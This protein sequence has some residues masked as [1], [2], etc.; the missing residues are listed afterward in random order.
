MAPTD[1]WTGVREP[2]PRMPPHARLGALVVDADACWCRVPWR[3][4]RSRH[5]SILPGSGLRVASRKA[6]AAAENTEALNGALM[7]K[8]RV[9][10]SANATKSSPLP[11]ATF[12][13]WKPTMRAR[14]HVISASVTP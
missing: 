14:P 1:G 3:V 7:P 4:C 11:T 9:M 13:V 2:I 8:P 10:P 12:R 6:P 5:L